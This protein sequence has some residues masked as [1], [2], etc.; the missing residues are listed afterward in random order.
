MSA[1][2]CWWRW[3]SA[4]HVVRPAT[5]ADVSRT[6]CGIGV[7]KGELVRYFHEIKPADRCR[8]CLRLAGRD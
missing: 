4:E 1:G 8:H 5:E 2:A 7:G 3:C 6:V